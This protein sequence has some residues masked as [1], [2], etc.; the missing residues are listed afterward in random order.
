MKSFPRNYRILLILLHKKVQAISNLVAPIQALLTDLQLDKG[1]P[2]T[3]QNYVELSKSS[4]LVFK[5]GNLF[6]SSIG[7]SLL[8]EAVRQMSLVRF[9]CCRNLMIFQR[10]VID[11]LTLTLPS[12][13]L[14]TIRSQFMP[15]VA[16]YLH[17]YFTMVWISETPMCLNNSKASSEAGLRRLNFLRASDVVINLNTSTSHQTVPVLR[18]FLETRALF[19][20]IFMFTDSNQN[21]IE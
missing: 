3:I 17:S 21:G 12:K 5:I 1:D 9:I 16:I 18:L 4:K 13:V 6:G 19:T 15:D 20:A 10:I 14:E 2:E 7:M 8:S 11:T